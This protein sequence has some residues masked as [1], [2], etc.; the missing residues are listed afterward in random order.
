MRQV[1]E[2]TGVPE[3]TIRSWERRFGLPRPERSGGNQRRYSL[4]DAGVIRAIQGAR[5]RGRTMEQAIEDVATGNHVVAR[6]D[7]VGGNRP[8]TVE[9]TS[10]IN[11]RMSLDGRLVDSLLALDEDR[12]GETLADRLWGSTVDSV[13]VDLLLP[14]WRTIGER[15]AAGTTTGIQAQFGSSWIERK[16]LAAFDQSNPEHGRRNVVVGAMHDHSGWLASL[17]YAI[18]LSRAGYAVTWL[19]DPVPVT[20]VTLTV[21]LRSPAAILMTG[22]SALARIA[23]GEALR[24]LAATHDSGDWNG[25]LAVGVPVPEIAAA[26]IPLHVAQSVTDFGQ[27]LDA[28]STTRRT[29]GSA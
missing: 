6:I 12:A 19:G 9:T 7:D 15:L 29:T 22:E 25:L 24:R 5:D 20:G 26:Y 3:N 10:S 8:A 4:G 17:C 13:C 27:A 11:G 16:L 28:W 14:A 2:L 18:V 21:D 1:S 23:I